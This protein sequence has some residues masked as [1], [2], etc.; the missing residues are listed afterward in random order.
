MGHIATPELF[1]VGRWG[2]E[3]RYMWQ[4]RCPSEQEGEVQS[5]VTHDSVEALSS[6]KVGSEA[7]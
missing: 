5:R 3:L 6:R 4:R 7:I 1:L 2:M